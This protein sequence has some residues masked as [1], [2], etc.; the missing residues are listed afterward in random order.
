VSYRPVTGA[1]DLSQ[2]RAV[3]IFTVLGPRT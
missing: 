1:G 3:D 2:P